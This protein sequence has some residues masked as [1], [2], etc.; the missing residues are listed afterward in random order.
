MRPS[1]KDGAAARP[2][3]HS[4]DADGN[5]W[6]HGCEAPAGPY[7]LTPVE[8]NPHPPAEGST[9]LLRRPAVGELCAFAWREEMWWPEERMNRVAY[10]A[11]WLASRGWKYICARLDAVVE[12]P[13]AVRGKK[14][15]SSE[16][17]SDA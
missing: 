13:K 3:H 12:E 9:H 17:T 1:D 6:D 2:L 7:L 5:Y 15:P 16:K 8:A 10:T 14:E 4:V 11:A